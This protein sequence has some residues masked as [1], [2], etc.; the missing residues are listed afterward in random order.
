M[1]SIL[2]GLLLGLAASTALVP[3]SAVAL[4][5]LVL[6]YIYS[7]LLPVHVTVLLTKRCIMHTHDKLVI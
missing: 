7:F 5:V 4:T 2:D 1:K 6:S 3:I